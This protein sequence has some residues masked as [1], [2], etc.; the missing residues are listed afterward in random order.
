MG[1]PVVSN[2]A[3]TGTSCRRHPGG[4]APSRWRSFS[5]CPAV[6]L[7]GTGTE[8]PRRA[9]SWAVRLEANR[10]AGHPGGRRA[11]ASSVSAVTA[12]VQPTAIGEK[13]VVSDLENT[14]WWPCR[15]LDLL[16]A[17]GA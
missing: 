1:G 13:L 6:A 8:R 4:T 17:K 10:L 14:L 12:P 2:D 15:Q 7:E 11:Q 9:N 16:Y 5:R 3:I